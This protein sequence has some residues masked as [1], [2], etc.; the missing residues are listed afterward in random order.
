MK[1][2]IEVTMP[3]FSI[4]ITAPGDLVKIS[5]PACNLALPRD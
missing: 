5:F 3:P 2:K 1:L 4:E